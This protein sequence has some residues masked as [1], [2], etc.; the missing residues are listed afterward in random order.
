VSH[1][2]ISHVPSSPASWRVASPT[3][4]ASPS[5]PPAPPTSTP[6]GR[7]D[8]GSVGPLGKYLVNNTGQISCWCIVMNIWCSIQYWK[9]PTTN[10]GKVKQK[11]EMFHF[12]FCLT[13][14]TTIPNESKFQLIQFSQVCSFEIKQIT[15]KSFQKH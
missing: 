11:F 1:S 7:T 14:F 5:S 12:N 4:V 15:W 3:I 10:R 6:I 8:A 2:V 13:R 9:H